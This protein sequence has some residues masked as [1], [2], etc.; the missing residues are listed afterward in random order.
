[1]VNCAACYRD[2]VVVCASSCVDAQVS[3]ATVAGSSASKG[4]RQQAAG[5][6]NEA[7]MSRDDLNERFQRAWPQQS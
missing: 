7:A 6:R 4:L 5:H 3:D 1:V 2:S